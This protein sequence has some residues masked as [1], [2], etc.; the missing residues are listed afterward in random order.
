MN[1]EKKAPVI[2][3]LQVG[4][5]IIDLVAR[6]GQPMKFN[7]IHHESQITKS[8]LYKYL[9]T[10]TQLGLLY[11]DKESGLYSLGSRLIEYGMIALDR[12]NV[13]DRVTPYL[14]DINRHCD[15]T[16]LFAMWTEDGPMITKMITGNQLMNI[17]AKI[18]TYLPA[19]T[20][21]G[22][23]F[24]AFM[25]EQDI[26]EWKEREFAKLSKTK[27]TQLEKEIEK[28]KKEGI[29]FASEPL[30]PQ[31]SSI[32]FPVLN[33]KEELVGSVILVGFNHSI[34]DQL[35]HPTSQYLLQMSR[36]ISEV[37]GYRDEL[38]V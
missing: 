3:S 24:C 8:N 21:S 25:E 1:N 31:V 35:D 33:F 32:A 7:D 20:A 38:K 10:L 14:Q 2:Q 34:P 9:N 13:I 15:E 4:L 5:S 37:F 18:G 19:T 11:R 6:Y 16:V 26:K 27:Q 30:V 36:E 22:K 28:V 12:E 17:G 29:S 23:V